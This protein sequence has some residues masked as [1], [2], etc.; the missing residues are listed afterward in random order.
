MPTFSLLYVVTKA[1]EM[2][3][4]YSSKYTRLNINHRSKP[5]FCRGSRARWP[6]KVPS[7]PKHSMILCLIL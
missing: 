7:N 4:C 5:E 6:L 1:F 3:L 2:R